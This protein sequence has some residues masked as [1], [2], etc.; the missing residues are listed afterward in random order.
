MW[1]LPRSVADLLESCIVSCLLPPVAGIA[2][3]SPFRGIAAMM[4]K[5]TVPAQVDPKDSTSRVDDPTATCLGIAHGVRWVAR[6]LFC[7]V[8]L[9]LWTYHYQAMS[10][11]FLSMSRSS[12]THNISLKKFTPCSFHPHTQRVLSAA[13]PRAHVKPAL[14]CHLEYMCSSFFTVIPPHILPRCLYSNPFWLARQARLAKCRVDNEAAAVTINCRTP[15][16]P[17][18]PRTRRSPHKR[19]AVAAINRRLPQSAI[20]TTIIN[21]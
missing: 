13:K 11:T 7:K 20:F 12:D 4:A 10:R 14:H 2:D 19:H 17:V 3:G 5:K 6:P 9:Q 16:S 21:T 18:L 15:P 1:T 8:F